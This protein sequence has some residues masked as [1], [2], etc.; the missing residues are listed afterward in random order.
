MTQFILGVV[1]LIVGYFTYGKVV[2]KHFGPDED[3]VTPAH[4]LEDGIDYVP[5]SKW[6]VFLI[7]LLNIAGLGPIFGAIQGALFGPVAFVWIAIGCIFAGGVHDYFSAMLSVRHDGM[8]FSEIT[9]EYLGEGAR[10]VMRVFSVVLLVLIGTVFLSGPAGLLAGLNLFGLDNFNVWLAIIFAYY[11]L[12]TILPV[13]KI[14]GKLYP[15]FGISF[16]V[17]AVGIG[18]NLV[19]GGYTLPTFTLQGMHPKGL[20]VW[21]M[22]F[23]TI[24][25]GAISGFHV[26]QSPM[27]ARTLNNEKEG[28]QVFYGAMIAEGII[29]MVWAAAAMAFFGNIDGLAEFYYSSIGGPGGVVNHISIALMGT[30]GGLLAM[31]GVIAAPITSGD[32]AFRSARLTIADALGIKQDK[33][34][35]RLLLAAPLFVISFILTRIDFD[36]IWR[37]F[38][39]ANQTLAMIALWTVSAYLVREKKSHWMS[40]IPAVFMSGVSGTYLIQAPEGFG[41]GPEIAYPVGIVVAIAFLVLFLVRSK[42]LS[43][44]STETA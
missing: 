36:I 30:V 40:T 24:T 3:R 16:I 6:R 41:L 19:K 25:C 8:S 23:T 42:K 37:Y 38:A 14:I 39:W 15:L 32:T 9:G 21:A 12:A 35:S 17:M 5:M 26:T 1:I 28:R 29:A 34:K 18:F 4:R 11:F 2:E 43:D 31:V 10:Q 44:T 13:D 20:P 33:T 7:Q 27:M 22:L